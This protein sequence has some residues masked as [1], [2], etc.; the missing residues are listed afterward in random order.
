MG[1]LGLQYY[2]G[3]T[4]ATVESS[5]ILCSRAHLSGAGMDANESFCLM[6]AQLTAGC[7]ISIYK[8]S[9]DRS[10]QGNCYEP[11]E[12]RSNRKLLDSGELLREKLLFFSAVG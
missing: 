4:A 6:T 1:A 10:Y 5:S 11:G 8:T 3:G 12:R 2:F 7:Y 9:M